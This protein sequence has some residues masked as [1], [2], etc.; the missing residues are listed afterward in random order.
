MS[1]VSAADFTTAY[2]ILAERLFEKKD[3]GQWIKRYAYTGIRQHDQEPAE[4]RPQTRLD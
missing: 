2:V 3:F 4:T 1:H